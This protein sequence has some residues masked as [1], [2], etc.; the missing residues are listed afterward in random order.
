MQVHTVV[1]SLADCPKDLDVKNRGAAVV[2]VVLVLIVARDSFCAFGSSKGE[3]RLSCYPGDDRA[4]VEAKDRL[5]R[6][7]VVGVEDL[8]KLDALEDGLRELRRIRERIFIGTDHNVIRLYK[9]LDVE[10]RAHLVY[11]LAFAKGIGAAENSRLDAFET[12]AGTHRGR[13]LSPSKTTRA[14]SL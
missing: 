11:R 7:D 8:G 1:H 12:S 2:T 3:G 6:V 13:T 4:C 14:N 5:V 10:D 9:Q